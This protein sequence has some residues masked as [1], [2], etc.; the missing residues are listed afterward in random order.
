MASRW[1][2]GRVEVLAL[3]DEIGERLAAGH[4][5]AS[6]YNALSRTRQI[7]VKY[8]SFYMNVKYLVKGQPST[9][10]INVPPPSKSP[11]S[12]PA[13]E[14]DPTAGTAD[15]GRDGATAPFRL[16]HFKKDSDLTG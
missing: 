7:T 15:R 9:A 3:R 1:G 11:L 2:Q 16:D 10:T 12:K 8:T 5:I 13:V 4:S 14:R 6:I